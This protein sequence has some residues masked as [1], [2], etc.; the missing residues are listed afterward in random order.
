M[1]RQLTPSLLFFFLIILISTLSLS[2]LAQSTGAIGGVVKDD[3]NRETIPYVNIVVKGTS[4]GAA[5]DENGRY[6]ISNLPPGMYELRATAVGFKSQEV[7]VKVDAVSQLIQDFYLVHSTVELN[8]VLVYGASMRRERITEAPASVSI[9]EARDIARNAGHGQLPKLLEAEPGID[10]V[11]SGLFDFNVNTRGFN[12]SLN[13]RL[14]ILLDGRDLGTAFLGATEWNGLTIPLEEIGRIELIRGPGSALYG[15]N[16]FNGVMNITSIPPRAAKGT[17]AIVGVGELNMYRGDIRHADAL[18]PWS[19]RVNLGAISGK[20]F[21]RVRTGQKFEYSG[22]HPL[23]ND[24][25]K[26]LNTA[27]VKNMYA[28]A[29]LDYDYK[30]GDVATIEGGIAQ[31]ENEVIVTG[32]GRVQVQKAQRPWGRI[33]YTGHGLNIA[34]WMSGR[35]NV[36]PE[37]SLATGLNLYQDALMSQ[38]EAQYSFN[39]LENTLFVVVGASQRFVDVGTQGT[40]MLHTRHDNMTGVYTQVEY[41]FTPTLKGLF[42]ARWDRSTLHPSQFSP[43]AAVVWSFLEGHS[44]RATF[45]RAFQSPNYSEL[46]LHV[47]HPTRPLAYYGNMVE[48]PP[49]LSGFVS[50]VQPGPLKDMTVEKIMGYEIGYKGVFSNALFL[51]ADAYFSELTD[52]VTDLAVG[53]NPRFPNTGGIYPGDPIPTRTIWSYVNAGKAQEAGMEVGASYYLSDQWLLRGNYSLYSFEVMEKNLNDVLIPNSPKY[54]IGGGVTYTHPDGH[55][56]GFNIKYI[57]SFDWAA[58]IFQ[59]KIPSYALIDL[60][61]SYHVSENIALTLIVSNL[62]DREHYEIFGGSLLRRRTVA[63]ASYSW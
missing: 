11:Q 19:Y 5:S 45:N 37:V 58:G 3:E 40:L 53:V 54:R 34:G 48:N 28:S 2:L 24:E 20:T 9:I 27:P 39:L 13:R 25:V 12:S 23:F 10:M 44:L 38:G 16:A 62:L 17:K 43:K 49:G 57:P 21:S 4:Y 51:T 50:G 35:K 6:S 1:H 41:R 63:T 14:L 29:R 47:K 15:A 42:A 36:E 8:E 46:F 26:N 59:G 32:I 22:F 7:T 31:V 61:G 30:D 56:A 52:F 33:S 18:G 55:D 60:S